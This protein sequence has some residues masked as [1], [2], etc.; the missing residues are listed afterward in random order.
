MAKSDG[1]P[2]ADVRVDCN[3]LYKATDSVNIKLAPLQAIQLAKGLLEKAQGILD[4]T[5]P[6]PAVHLWSKGENSEVLY[7]GFG[8]AR[9]GPRTNRRRRK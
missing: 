9:K 1:R 4:G 7:C 3:S 2:K 8:K 6:Y 5:S